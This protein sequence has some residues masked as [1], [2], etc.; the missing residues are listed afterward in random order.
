MKTFKELR[1]MVGML[2]LLA[3]II[4]AAGFMLNAIVQG[5]TG[6]Y[7]VLPEYVTFGN[8][9]LVLGVCA[10][11]TVLLLRGGRIDSPAYPP[12]FNPKY[13]L[14]EKAPP[15]PPQTLADILSA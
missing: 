15:P 5:T 2:S 3:T 4:V 14:P 10:G 6:Y 7:M 13:D 8:S 9:L 12:P 11:L 1:K